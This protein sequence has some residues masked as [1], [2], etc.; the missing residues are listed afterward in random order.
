LSLKGISES[1][2]HKTI[3]DHYTEPQTNELGDLKV[4]AIKTTITD[5]NDDG[6]HDVIATVESNGTCGT[7]G[8]IGSIFVS[9]ARG[10]LEAISFA[11]AFKEIEVLMSITQGMHDLRINGDESNHMIWNGITYELKRI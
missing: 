9:G 11:Y 1:E 4:D 2:L 6:Q 10:Q 5:L 3:L 7:G 8:C